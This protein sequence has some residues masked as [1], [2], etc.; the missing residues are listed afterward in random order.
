MA[1]EAVGR[2]ISLCPLGGAAETGMTRRANWGGGL[3][4][5]A[6]GVDRR[7]NWGECD[8]KVVDE[9]KWAFLACTCSDKSKERFD[10]VWEED[11][12]TQPVQST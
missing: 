9:N 12:G 7:S 8:N 1:G 10:L 5:H 6:A 2:S 3:R 11:G 4:G